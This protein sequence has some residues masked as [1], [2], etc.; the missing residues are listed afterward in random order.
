[1]ARRAVEWLVELQSDP[2][3]DALRREWSHWRMAD[4]LHEQAWQRIE[5][6]NGRFA[7]LGA[8]ATA[9][10]AQ[11]ALTPR[12]SVRRRQA[13]Q[14][15]ALV[16]FAGG[17]AW[18]LQR[19]TPWREWTADLRTGPGDRRSL[20]LED[21]TQLV[22]NTRTAVDLRYGDTERRLRLLAG[23][24]LVDSGTDARERPLLVETA[25]G[26][27]LAM[28]TRFV[29]R[30]DEAIGDEAADT[31]VSVFDGAVR[32][33]PRADRGADLV[34]P[35]GKQ[36]HFS[37][38]AVAPPTP[39][40]EDCAAAWVDGML[41]ARGMRLDDFL[42]ELGRYST[43]PLRC[44]PAV[45]QMRVSGTYPLA[46]VGKVLDTV[47]ATLSLEVQTLTRFWGRQVVSVGLAPRRK[48]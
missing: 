4:P 28:G 20:T 27:V 5:S 18:T 37:G 35:A 14:T 32:L 23:E 24:L 36:S 33:V 48:G 29:V 3:S 15:L 9:M 43:C 40:V 46:D 10:V 13:V 8:P 34:V 21:G 42:A 7:G 11:A 12:R 22:L 25:Q 1:M 39:V 47:A 17:T 45:A 30:Q 26:E 6:V 19:H 41:V 16:F 44:D 38:R 31:Q 2:A